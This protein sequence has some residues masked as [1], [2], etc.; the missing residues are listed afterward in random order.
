[1]RIL[2]YDLA[3][4]CGYAVG[5]D[6]CRPDHGAFTLPRIDGGRFG[7]Y[8]RRFGE[9]ISRHIDGL[10]PTLII[11][12]SPILARTTTL[13]VARA[14]YCLGPRLEEA[15]DVAGVPCTEASLGEVRTHFLGV[16]KCP[17][18]TP[19]IKAAVMA[20]CRRRGWRPFDDNAG[21]ALAL[22]DYARACRIPGWANQ[23]LPLLEKATA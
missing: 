11:Y 22:L 6:F 20:E 8:L 7:P 13:H 1:M 19:A 21:D 12:E 14:L 4:T 3:R 10:K 15:A 9:I 17:R 18:S 2:A 5:E 16:G 23:G